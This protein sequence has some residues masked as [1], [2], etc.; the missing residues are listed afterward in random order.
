MTDEMFRVFTKILMHF[1]PW[2]MTQHDYNVAASCADFEARKRG[3]KDWVDAYVNWK[4]KEKV[5]V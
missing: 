1:D 5:N 3:F 4:E 2:P